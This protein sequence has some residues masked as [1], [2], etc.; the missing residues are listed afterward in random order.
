MSDEPPRLHTGDPASTL[1]EGLSLVELVAVFE[2]L[3]RSELATVFEALGACEASVV[4]R[5]SDWLRARSREWLLRW[6]AQ[7]AARA[8]AATT[9]PLARMFL[10]REAVAAAH[11][12]ADA[13]R[14][15]ALLEA[16]LAAD[17]GA[18]RAATLRRA[19]TR[20]QDLARGEPRGE[21]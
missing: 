10:R 18:A 11:E 14:A 12:H 8:V 1:G 15:L 21:G 19:L 13:E 5:A 6:E 3:G 17:L 20:V 2:A 7:R 4:D 16:A 9:D